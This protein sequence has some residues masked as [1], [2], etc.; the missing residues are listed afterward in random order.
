MCDVIQQLFQVAY[1]GVI[2]TWKK[3]ALD[4]INKAQQSSW[5]TQFEVLTSELEESR[6][7]LR[8]SVETAQWLTERN[9]AIEQELYTQQKQHD[10]ALAARDSN[11]C[12]LQTN[13]ERLEADLVFQKKTGEDVANHNR[14]I[15]QELSQKQALIQEQQILLD[16]SR[17]KCLNILTAD[18]LQLLFILLSAT[19]HRCS[20][21]CI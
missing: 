9:K 19:W 4:D 13:L 15:I 17:A 3:N 14:L 12:A 20:Y 5:H 21:S 2:S 11:V 18:I 7:K 10:S 16:N 1:T 8:I 6:E